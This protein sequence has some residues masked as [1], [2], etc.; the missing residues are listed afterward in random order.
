[1][2]KEVIYRMVALTTE[3]REL[4]KVV[5]GLEAASESLVRENNSLKEQIAHLEAEVTRY[6]AATPP[7]AVNT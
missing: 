3:N 2:Q 1:V 6:R 5:A 4:A 7:V